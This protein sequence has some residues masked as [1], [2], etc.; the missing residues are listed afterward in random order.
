MGVAHSLIGVRVQSGDAKGRRLSVPKGGDVR[1]T[2]ARVRK[3]L[4]DM[5]DS[6]F[7]LDGALVLDLFC[8]SGS[9]GIEALSR[10]AASVTFVDTSSRSVATTRGNLSAI[11]AIDRCGVVKMD[12]LTY[13]R[14][15]GRGAQGGSDTPADL[16]FCDP[17]YGYA[18]WRELLTLMPRGAIVAAEAERFLQGESPWRLV[19]EKEYGGTFI[20]LL[21]CEEGED[22]P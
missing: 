17:P 9:L 15:L 2:T 12:S 8:G 7:S 20:T 14:S 3:S 10:G 6:R 4:F 11:G 16:V 1:P 22:G 21:L 18:K 13:L 5:I 19:R